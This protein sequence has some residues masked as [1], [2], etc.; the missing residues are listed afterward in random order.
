VNRPSDFIDRSGASRNPD[1]DSADRWLKSLRGPSAARVILLLCRCDL[2]IGVRALAG[3]A[4]V[5][6]SASARVLDLLDREAVIRRGPQGEVVAVGKRSLVRRWTDDYGL[7]RSN[8]VTATVDPRGF[9][10]TLKS[11]RESE[12]PY[13]VTGSLAQR[14]YLPSGVVPVPLGIVTAPEY[15]AARSVLLDALTAFESI[16]TRLCLWAR[17]PSICTPVQVTT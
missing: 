13:A 7:T 6:V 5:G 4:G 14:N 2:P 8:E 12:I 15:V 1:P 16:L 10:H 11:L 3:S 17:R 9:D